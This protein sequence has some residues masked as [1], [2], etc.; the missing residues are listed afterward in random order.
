MPQPTTTTTTPRTPLAARPRRRR[1]LPWR[2]RLGTIG[3]VALGGIL[4]APARVELGRL[5]PAG[6]GLPWATF[7]VNV[8][9]SFLLGIVAT[10]LVE[11]IGPTRHL[12]PLAATGFCGSFTTFSTFAVEVDLR[13]RAGDV[14]GAFGY[15]A[16][17]L[18]AG[19]AAVAAGVALARVLFRGKAVR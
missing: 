9:G 18:V 11:R 7:T 12:G 19:V 1:T 13:L 2:R 3:A 14:A 5:L 10:L 15:G 4:G 8:V 6:P 16:A 17:S